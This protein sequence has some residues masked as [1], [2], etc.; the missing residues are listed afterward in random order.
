M[1]REDYEARLAAVRNL[2]GGSSEHHRTYVGPVAQYDFMG[3]TQFRLLTGLGLREDH[4]LMDLGCGSLR[5]G[6]FLIQYLLPGRYVGVEPNSWLWQAALADEIGEDIL[7]LKEPLFLSDP[8]VTSAAIGGPVDF[9]VAQSIYS[10]TGKDLFLRSL[11]RLAKVINPG[12][13]LLFTVV[14]PE[15]QKKKVPPGERA[16]GWIYPG[17]VTF[18]EES[19]LKFCQRFGFTAQRLP[20]FHPRQTWYRATLDGSMLDE[21]QIQAMGTGRPLFDDRFD[22]S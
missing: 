18:K 14:S 3:A 6:R 21:T 2:P 22:A 8:D 20:W 11:K 7:R 4:R 10:H 1:T 13:Q 12:G 19:V 17:V 16:T 15:E 9:V 5:A